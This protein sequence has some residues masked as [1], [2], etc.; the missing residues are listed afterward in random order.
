MKDRARSGENCSVQKYLG[1]CLAVV[2]IFPD[3]TV[4]FI[5]KAG[6]P[7]SE[8]NEMEEI[9]LERCFWLL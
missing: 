7:Q 9:L 4:Y 2:N 6:F 5:I 8:Q 3:D 1:C